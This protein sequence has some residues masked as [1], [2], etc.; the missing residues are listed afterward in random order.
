[1]N[2]AF[3]HFHPLRDRAERKTS[4]SQTL[5]LAAVADCFGAT[6]RRGLLLN[7][8]ILLFFCGLQFFSK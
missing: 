1:V 2:S 8:A 7:I 6:A 3:A 4:L 5:N